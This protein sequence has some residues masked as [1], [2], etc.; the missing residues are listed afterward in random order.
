VLEQ[1]KESRPLPRQI[2]VDNGPE[3]ISS[4]LAAWCDNHQIHL[5]FIQ[6]G[7][8]MQN[9][10][11]ERSNRSFRE[12]VID[13]NLFGSLTEVRNAV[14]QWMIDYNEE[15]PHDALGNL[16]PTLYRQQLAQTETKTARS[17]TFQM[18]R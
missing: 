18:C 11:V 9:G 3:L 15:R 6:P 1:L 13:A 8:P 16:P 2:R 5:H 17:S 12:E 10:Y 7:R 14:H 4:K